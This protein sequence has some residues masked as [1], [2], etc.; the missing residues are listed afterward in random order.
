MDLSL[1]SFAD[2]ITIEQAA[3]LWIGVDPANN[4]FSRPSDEASKVAAMLQALSGG[5]IVISSPYARRSALWETY[6]RHHGPD[7][8]PA[9]L[10]AQ[11]ATRDFNPRWHARRHIPEVS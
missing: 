4:P 1:W 8:D 7:G 3:C 2:P 10:V 11:G 9:I 6:R 5:V